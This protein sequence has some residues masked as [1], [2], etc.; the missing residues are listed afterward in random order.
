MDVFPRDSNDCYKRRDR[1]KARPGECISVIGLARH[2]LRSPKSCF[3]YHRCA[4][5]I[6]LTNRCQSPNCPMKSALDF[7]IKVAPRTIL[8]INGN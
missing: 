7:V 6:L 4:F 5:L 3:P 2:L 1:F 8:I